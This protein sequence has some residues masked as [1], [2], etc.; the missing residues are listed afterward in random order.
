[1]LSFVN[2]DVES[3]VGFIIKY[4]IPLYKHTF[5]C[6][7]AVNA[8]VSNIYYRR[9]VTNGDYNEEQSLE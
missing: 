6:T 7:K 5:H 3:N 2:S 8:A 4:L 1:M 9:I